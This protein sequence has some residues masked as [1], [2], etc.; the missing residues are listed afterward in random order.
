[1][2]PLVLFS[3]AFLASAGLVSCTSDDPLSP[4]VV[5]GTWGAEG[6]ILELDENGGRVG[7]P[8]ADGT[9]EEPVTL[10]RENGFE[11]QGE[12]LIG[13]VPVRA[14]LAEYR[15]TVRN[16][17]MDFRIVLVESGELFGDYEL[18]KGFHPVIRHCQ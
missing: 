13:P 9:L 16:D 5:D 3:L 2:R 17:R 11:V 14:V 4:T 6:V 18:V 15:G 7:F 1:M 8:C 10:D 12:M